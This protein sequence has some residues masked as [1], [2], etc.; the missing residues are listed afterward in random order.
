[1]RWAAAGFLAASVAAVPAAA[2][3]AID[4]SR[5]WTPAVGQARVDAPIYMTVTNHGDAPDSLVRVR[6]PADLAD[7][8][9][10]HATDR[11]E[12]GTAMREVKS[13]AVPAGG[14][15]TL[16]PDGSHLMLL[17]VREP[18]REGQTFRCS[19]V[20]QKAGTIPVEVRVAPGGAKE[21]P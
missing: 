1:M 10:K 5:A 20:F 8:T 11:G 21:A 4:V 16:A 15:V 13:L 7:A 9:E 2:E 14:T 18:L 3:G 17:N 19:L 12:G 6:C